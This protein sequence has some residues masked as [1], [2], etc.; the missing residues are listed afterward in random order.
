MI[1]VTHTDASRSKRLE[2]KLESK[3]YLPGGLRPCVF[4][5]SG[6]VG[7]LPGWVKL[8][9][10]INPVILC[11]IESIVRF[12]AELQTPRL[13]IAELEALEQRDVPVV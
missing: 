5:K 3:H 12:E 1:F 11:V 4:P 7:Q 9:V 2:S 13:V 8:G 10:G 6:G